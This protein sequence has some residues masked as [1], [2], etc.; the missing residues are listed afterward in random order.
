MSIK[1]KIEKKKEWRK[2]RSGSV[3]KFSDCF[4]QKTILG[5]SVDIVEYDFSKEK[6]QN[7]FPYKKGYELHLYVP[8]EKSPT[9]KVIR[10]N[11]YTY[12]KLNFGKMEKDAEIII[13]RILNLKINL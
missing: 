2:Y 10:I 5:I 11:N 6:E 7:K 1:Q 8:K 4:Y 12:N 3:Y 9:Q 13:R